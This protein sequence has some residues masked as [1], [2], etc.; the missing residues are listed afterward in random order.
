M[1]RLIRALTF[2]CLLLVC[3]SASRAD[4]LPSAPMPRLDPGRHT[5]VIRGIDTDRA[6]HWLVSASDD[7]TVRVWDAGSG[8]MQRVLRPPIG[9]K[10]EDDGKLYAVAISPDGRL[11][12]CGGLTR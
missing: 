6:G 4:E 5:A 8:R 3:F 7:K 1:V 2:Y 9:E 10:E 12:A 11:V